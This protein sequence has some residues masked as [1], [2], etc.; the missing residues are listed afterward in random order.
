MK[1]VFLNCRQNISKVPVMELMFS[2]FAV[3]LS[4]HISVAASVN[5]LFC[6]SLNFSIKTKLLQKVL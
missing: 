3:S 4:V 1:Q 2:N 6:A 5:F